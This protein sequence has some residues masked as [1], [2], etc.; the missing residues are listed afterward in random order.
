MKHHLLALGMVVVLALGGAVVGALAGRSSPTKSTVTVTV[1]EYRISLSVKTLPAGPVLLVVHNAGR[2]AHALSVSGPG[3]ATVSTPAIKPGATKMLSVTF[4]GGT[5]RVWCPVGGHAALGMKAS[6]A[7]RGAP[8]TPIVTST[9]ST[10][11]GGGG[12]NDYGP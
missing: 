11:G 2:F 9:N 7:V 5:V 4:G 1:R 12:Y 10:T 8:I 6:L 3:L